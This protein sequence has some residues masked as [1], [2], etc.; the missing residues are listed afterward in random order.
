[1]ARGFA[2]GYGGGNN[3]Q[4]LMRQAQK[5]QQE[6]ERV[7]NSRRKENI[8]SVIADTTGTYNP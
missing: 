7:K 6:M 2:G 1:M 5:M 4:Q 8:T 3:M